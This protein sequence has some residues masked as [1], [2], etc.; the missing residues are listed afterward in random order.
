MSAGRIC[1]RVVQT[2]TAHEPVFDAARRM[3]DHHVGTLVVVDDDRRP[4][5]IVTDRD[6]TVR[7]VAEGCNPANTHL[8]DVMT[9]VV[10][11]V[12]EDTPIEAALSTMAA[13]KTRRMVVT[14]TDGRLEGVLSLDDVIDLLVEEA[15]TIGRLL[16]SQAPV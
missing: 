10:S 1:T 11:C 3:R 9:R 16:R 8:S 5:G 15:G 13:A 4:I 6:L 12:E 2:A 14:G 7:C